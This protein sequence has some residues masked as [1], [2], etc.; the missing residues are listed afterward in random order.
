MLSGIINVDNLIYIFIT[1]AVTVMSIVIH[2]LSHGYAA[3]LCG[4]NTARIYGRLSLNPLKHIDWIGALCLAVFKF[5]W[6]KPVPVNVN[7]F[8]N[9]K[10]DIIIVSLAGPVSNF[11]LAFVATF[12][13]YASIRYSFATNLLYQIFMSIISLNLGLGV[14]NLIPIPPLDGSK[15][16]GVFLRGGTAYKYYSFE[17]YGTVLLL[18]VFMIPFVSRIFHFVLSTCVN[19]IYSGYLAIIKLIFGVF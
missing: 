1:L 8:N 5:G 16:L 13:M 4:D 17:K 10:K 9:Y 7:N 3:Y 11:I 6:A 14:F 19:G 2:E 15:I 18:I 12:I